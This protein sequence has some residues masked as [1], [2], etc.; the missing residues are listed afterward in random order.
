MRQHRS[1]D[2]QF[3]AVRPAPG[4]L[5]GH[6]SG[7]TTTPRRKYPTARHGGPSTDEETNPMSAPPADFSFDRRTLLRSTA[8][9]AGAAAAG[10]LLYTALDASPAHASNLQTLQ[11]RFVDWRFGMFIH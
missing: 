9:A 10:P 3:P 11:Q 6:R 2:R 1:I 4:Q 5:T 8:V 7:R